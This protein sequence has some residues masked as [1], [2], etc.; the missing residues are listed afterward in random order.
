MTPTNVGTGY[1]SMST[2][3][4]L[5]AR[6]REQEAVA[7]LQIVYAGPS[8]VR[9]AKAAAQGIDRHRNALAEIAAEL[10]NRDIDIADPPTTTELWEQAKEQT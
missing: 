5:D 6:N 8:P 2:P 3:G 10:R 4:L 7:A 9:D 1:G